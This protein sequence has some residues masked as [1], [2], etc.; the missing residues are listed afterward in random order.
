M[1]G[2][3]MTT[4]WKSY[5][6]D[7][8]GVKNTDAGRVFRLN[9]AGKIGY[10]LL[11]DLALGLK[12]SLGYTNS[13]SDSTGPAPQQ[14]MILAGPFVRK[15]L[16]A[17]VFGEAGAGFGLNQVGKGNKTDL[18]SADLGLGYTYFLNHNIALEPQFVVVYSKHKAGVGNPVTYTEIGPEFRFGI[19]A[20]LFKPKL[21]TPDNRKL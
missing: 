18:L 11:E 1:L 3:D 13:K 16:K 17:G 8:G 5:S 9:G 10:F 14:V 20:F 12:G 15:Y 7:Q 19:Q 6:L 4:S 2:G 21:A